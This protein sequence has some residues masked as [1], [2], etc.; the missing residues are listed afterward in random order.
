MTKA[1]PRPGPQ[2]NQKSGARSAPRPSGPRLLKETNCGYIMFSANSSS[3]AP[4]P[5]TKPPKTMKGQ[6]FTMSC[7]PILPKTYVSTPQVKV[8]SGIATRIVAQ[9][10]GPILAKY[11][12]MMGMTGIT[13]PATACGNCDVKQ[14]TKFETNAVSRPMLIPSDLYSLF[15]YSALVG[16]TIEPREMPSVAPWNTEKSATSRLMASP[17]SRSASS[18]G[19]FGSGR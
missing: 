14:L 6:A 13:T 8:I 7:T 17:G 11:R 15:G 1:M 5:A 9:F 4:V 19:V 3:C 12:A 2:K 16:K 10:S 18:E